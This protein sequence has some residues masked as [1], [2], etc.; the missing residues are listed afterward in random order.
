MTW[1]DALTN[2]KNKR[3]GNYTASRNVEKIIHTEEFT[4]KFTALKRESEIKSWCRG[5]K[6]KYKIKPVRTD[7][8]KF[9]VAPV[10][11]QNKFYVFKRINR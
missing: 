1:I 2:T 9:K 6:L 3:G 7:I 11:L 8:V 10:C 5:K 4:I